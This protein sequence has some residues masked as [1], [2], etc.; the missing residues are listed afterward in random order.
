MKESKN[1]TEKRSKV[2]EKREDEKRIETER[3]VFKFESKK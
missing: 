2:F 1:K 3:R